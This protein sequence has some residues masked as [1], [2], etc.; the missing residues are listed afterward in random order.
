MLT[1]GSSIRSETCSQLGQDDW[2]IRCRE[3]GHRQLIDVKALPFARGSR[4]APF[5]RAKIVEALESVG[6][7]RE[8]TCSVY[9]NGLYDGELYNIR[10]SGWGEYVRAGLL[11]LF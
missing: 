2:F 7:L 8:G 6:K 4:G 1:S 11:Q 5:I 10:P 9:G 3:D